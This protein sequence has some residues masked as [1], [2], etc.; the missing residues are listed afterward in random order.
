[1]FTEEQHEVMHRE[2]EKTLQNIQKRMD[3]DNQLIKVTHEMCKRVESL[4]LSVDNISGNVEK[5][6]EKFDGVM[7][8]YNDRITRLETKP[9]TV[10]QIVAA[11][12]VLA[13]GFFLGGM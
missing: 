10:I 4:A 13:V 7:T 8:D 1:M 12:L 3:D 9:S 6:T 11:V 5:L 2:I